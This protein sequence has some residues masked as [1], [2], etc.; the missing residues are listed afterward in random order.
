MHAAGSGLGSVYA[1]MTTVPDLAE[2]TS[3]GLLEVYLRTRVLRCGCG[4]QME[5]PD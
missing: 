2:Q 3:E 1:P 4:F 5:I